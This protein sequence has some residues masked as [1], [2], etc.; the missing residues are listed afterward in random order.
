MKR[1]HR[2]LVLTILP[3]LLAVTATRRAYPQQP[4][5]CDGCS[6]VQGALKASEELKPGMSRKD[7]EAQFTF[8]GGMQTGYWGRYVFRRCHSIKIDVRFTGAL[9]G[10][11]AEGLPTDRIAGVSRPYLETPFMD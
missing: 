10:H 5:G 3:P 2:L 6:L 1:V 9:D 11:G 4:S 8:D 7:V